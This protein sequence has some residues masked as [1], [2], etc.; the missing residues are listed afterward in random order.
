MKEQT[1]RS[2]NLAMLGR[3]H[4]LLEQLD[5]AEGQPGCAGRQGNGP[6]SSICPPPSAHFLIYR[7]PAWPQEVLGDGVPALG[8]SMSRFQHTPRVVVFPATPQTQHPLVRALMGTTLGSCLHRL[9][10]F[11]T[12]EPLETLTDTTSSLGH[13]PTPLLLPSL[14]YHFSWRHVPINYCPAN[15][16]LWVCF[17][18]TQPKAGSLFISASQMLLPRNLVPFLPC[19]PHLLPA[20]PSP[21]GWLTRAPPPPTW[22]QM[23]SSG[24]ESS[25]CG[26]LRSLI[27]QRYF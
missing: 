21:P 23:A 26:D 10:H 8:P 7:H 22:K 11:L 9:Q 4:S 13:L 17:W 1:F 6:S 14:P 12:T 18:G 27:G 16:P 15:P 5:G 20:L 19:S 24:R 25:L 3:P 2:D